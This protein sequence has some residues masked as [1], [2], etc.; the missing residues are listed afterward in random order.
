VSADL[1]RTK[2]GQQLWSQD[3]D[4]KL[5]DVFALQSEIASAIEGRIRGRLAEKGGTVPE[6]IA[7]SGDVYALYSDA[8]AKV[9]KRDYGPEAKAG[10]DQLLRVVKM[11]P[12]FA[13]GWA[14]LA[15]ADRMALPS[16]KD[17]QTT[18]TSEAYARKALDLAP[19]LAAP[20]SARA[21]ALNLKGPVALAELQRAVEL[22][23]SD[24]EAWN[25]LVR[26]VPTRS[27]RTAEMRGG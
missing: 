18:D 10:R 21:F 23:P 19:N 20:H 26:G 22:D 27:R 15:I 14:T 16:Q 2:D 4:R 24:F 25:R 8:R 1:V 7:T 3:F 17:C 6:H 13:P 9:R 12:N 11:D 5:D